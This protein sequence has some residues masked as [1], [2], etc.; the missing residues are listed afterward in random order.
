MQCF[1]DPVNLPHQPYSSPLQNNLGAS[2]I[3]AEVSRDRGLPR[4]TLSRGPQVQRRN[5]LLQKKSIV[6]AAI[7]DV[8]EPPTRLGLDQI[9]GVLIV[10]PPHNPQLRL[11]AQY[12][13]THAERVPSVGPGWA[14]HIEYVNTHG[15]IKSVHSGGRYNE[16]I[17]NGDVQR[18]HLPSS[19]LRQPEWVRWFEAASDS[20]DE[21]RVPLVRSNTFVNEEHRIRI[22]LL[23]DG[24]EL[25][26]VSPEERLLPVEF[27]SR[28]L[29]AR[30]SGLK[31]RRTEPSGS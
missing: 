12:V 15:N 29:W 7:A 8:N 28:S 5:L 27:I 11:H 18:T 17:I 13:I 22:V 1:D 2:P 31:Q 26:V 30:N 4:V 14:W 3:P 21:I 16:Q 6:L 10:P 20:A 25:I 19:S 9:I 23:L 24:S